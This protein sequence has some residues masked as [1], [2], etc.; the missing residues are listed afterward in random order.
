MFESILLINIDYEYHA[1]Y[2]LF[3]TNHNKI[4]P[5]IGIKNMKLITHESPQI[6]NIC[7]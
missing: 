7:F 2:V 3:P 4:S 5:L 6:D 1:D